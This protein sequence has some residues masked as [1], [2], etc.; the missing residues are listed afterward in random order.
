MKYYL[1]QCKC[2]QKRRVL[3]VYK[4]LGGVERIMHHKNNEYCQN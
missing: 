3:V 2:I 1:G 4:L